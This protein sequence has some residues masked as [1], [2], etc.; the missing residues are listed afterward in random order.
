[1]IL[2]LKLFMRSSIMM[3]HVIT[4]PLAML[5]HSI[6]IEFPDITTTNSLIQCEQFSKMIII[7]LSDFCIY[8]KCN[9]TN[10]VH[11]GLDKSCVRTP[12]TTR[13]GSGQP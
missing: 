8:W 11:S 2:I 7:I 3:A 10:I 9:V 5:G 13:K 1:M 4:I 6:C 12:G